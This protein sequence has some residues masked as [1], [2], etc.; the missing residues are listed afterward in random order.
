MIQLCHHCSHHAQLA[1][2]SIHDLHF[3]THHS[4]ADDI[5]VYLYYTGN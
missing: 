3:I 5:S 2:V 1:D 4:L